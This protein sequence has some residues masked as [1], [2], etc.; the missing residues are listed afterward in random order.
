MKNRERPI[1][2]LA[3]LLS[4]I[5]ITTAACS[6]D[7]K[8]DIGETLG[9]KLSDYADSW[10]GYAEAYTFDSGSDRVRLVLDANG[11]GRLRV[12]DAPLAPPATDPNLGYPAGS[13][14]PPGDV[15]LNHDLLAVF[16]YPVHDATIETGRIQ[17]S[18]NPA[19]PYAVWCA[20]QTPV[21]DEATSNGAGATYLCALNRG[22]QFNKSGQ[23]CV[24]QAVGQ[25]DVPIDC[26]KWRLCTSEQVCQCTATACTQ[27][28]TSQAAGGVTAI[29]FDGAL[30]AGGNELT[31]TLVVGPRVT[32]RLHRE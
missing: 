31:G 17:L 1:S 14:S 23:D 25:A 19:D 7:R 24:E 12:G 16:Q 5:L 22:G 27:A 10:V 2:I 11:A 18:V 4:P 29:R 32:V 20:L 9:S 15:S 3:L 28:P 30:E 26:L 21:L 8:V 13:W 6:D